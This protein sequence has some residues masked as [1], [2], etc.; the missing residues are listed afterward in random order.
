MRKGRRK[1]SSS[2]GESE[3]WTPGLEKEENINQNRV[4]SLGWWLQWNSGSEIIGEIVIESRVFGSVES[5]LINGR[6]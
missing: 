6:V 5:V 3:G 1:R 4:G 2:K